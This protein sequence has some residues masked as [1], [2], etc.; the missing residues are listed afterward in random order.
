MPGIASYHAL[1][2]EVP[3]RIKHKEKQSQTKTLFFIKNS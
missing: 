3:I 2:Y 1:V